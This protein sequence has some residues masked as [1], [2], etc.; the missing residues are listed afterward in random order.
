MHRYLE[1]VGGKGGPLSTS[2]DKVPDG[3]RY[4]VL[5]VWIDG[6]EGVMDKEYERPAPLQNL[7]LP[8]EEIAL[9]GR[10]KVLRR[11][12]KEV[13][14]DVRVRRWLDEVPEDHSST[15][16]VDSEAHEADDWEGFAD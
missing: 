1:L 4:H 6:L 16:T 14:S 5:D 3:L 13:R 8:I 11:R 10:T 12:A 2:D 15:R 7:L 9:Q